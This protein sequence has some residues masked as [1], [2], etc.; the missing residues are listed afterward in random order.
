MTHMWHIFVLFVYFSEQK[1][2]LCI[3][4]F[5]LSN[6]DLLER[7][8]RAMKWKDWTPSK[9]SVLCEQHFTPD[10]YI[11]KG[12]P[13]IEGPNKKYLKEDAIPSIFYFPPH[14]IRATTSRNFPKK[15]K[16]PSPP[17]KGS[18][19]KSDHAGYIKLPTTE[20]KKLKKTLKVENKIIKRQKSP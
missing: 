13:A 5:P 2:Y 18:P 17:K 16:A 20:I 1:V 14:L 7:W 9:Y 3:F 11:C 19:A 10:D 12:K 6:P 15:R 8:I 4:R